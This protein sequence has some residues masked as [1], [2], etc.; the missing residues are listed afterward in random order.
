MDETYA[1]RDELAPEVLEAWQGS[2][3]AEGD[4]EEPRLVVSGLGRE[5]M[6]ATDSRLYLLRASYLTLGPG[7]ARATV[8][9]LSDLVTVDVG[10][11]WLFHRVRF[12]FATEQPETMLARLADRDKMRLAARMLS[13]MSASARAAAEEAVRDRHLRAQAEAAATAHGPRL[14]AGP[15]PTVVAGPMPVTDAAAQNG[16][17]GGDTVELLRGLWHLA[18]VGALTPAEYESKKAQLLARL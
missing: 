8:H 4:E 16:P 10:E 7:W 5:G 18:E 3:R 15:R 9:P 1:Y 2:R 13:T 17:V 11:G 6:V 12:A 14:V